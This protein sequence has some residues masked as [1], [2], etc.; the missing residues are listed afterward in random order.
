M[1][2]RKTSLSLRKSE[3]SDN[4]KLIETKL[5]NKN[6]EKTLTRLNNNKGKNGEGKK[7]DTVGNKISKI[8][9][10]RVNLKKHRATYTQ[11]QVHIQT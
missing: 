3:L 11:R 5:K 2:A 6:A 8:I 9:Y 10:I 7:D 1:Q 4:Q